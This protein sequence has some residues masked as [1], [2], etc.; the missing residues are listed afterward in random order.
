M[1][2][3]ELLIYIVIVVFVVFLVVKYWKIGKRN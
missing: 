3:I 1:E 2:Q